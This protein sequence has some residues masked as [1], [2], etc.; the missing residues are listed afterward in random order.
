MREAIVT[1]SDMIGDRRDSHSTV[2]IA[3]RRETWEPAVTRIPAVA[4]VVKVFSSFGVG[5]GVCRD[6]GGKPRE[7]TRVSG[8]HR[9]GD[10]GAAMGPCCAGR[11][12]GDR[13]AL[14]RSPGLAAPLLMLDGPPTAWSCAPRRPGAAPP[15]LSA[16]A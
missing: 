2:R 13:V 4:R 11:G 16:L 8:C 5:A 3:Q 9:S 10:V 1:M 14:P 7:R 15:S 6:G 12:P